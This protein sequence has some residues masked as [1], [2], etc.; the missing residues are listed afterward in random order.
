M[1]LNPHLLPVTLW[2]W[3]FLAV[4]VFFAARSI[5]SYYQNAWLKTW[6]EGFDSQITALGVTAASALVGCGTGT[7]ITF[8]T[9]SWTSNLLSV[10]WSGIKRKALDTSYMGTTM[11]TANTT[12]FGSMTFIPSSLSDPGSLKFKVQFNPDKLPLVDTAA[13]TITVTWPKGANTVGA[14]WAATGFV[15]D[16]D[17]TSALESIME[18]DV[19]CKISGNVSLT[20]ATA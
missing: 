8:G 16:F 10:G 17:M 11:L 14:N 18:A 9:S 1:D 19:T 7:S 13:E 15:T 5:R 4:M 20:K 2:Q 12:S 3:A 6:W